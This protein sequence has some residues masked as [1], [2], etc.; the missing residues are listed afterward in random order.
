MT[1]QR[2]TQEIIEQ[3]PEQCPTCLLDDAPA[4]VDAF[5]SHEKLSEAM[6][7]LIVTETGGHAIAL[8]G[9]WGSGKS[10]VI[11]LLEKRLKARNEMLDARCFCF[12]AWRHSGDP[13]RR[14]F[15]EGIISFFA[16]VGWVVESDWQAD[17]DRLARR[18]EDVTQV[19]RQ[20]LTLTGGLVL[21]AALFV[22]IGYKLFE[23][24]LVNQ[25][26]WRFLVSIFLILLPVLVG[27]I[28][29][30]LQRH[31][32]RI[33]KSCWP[34][35]WGRINK[36]WPQSVRI[37]EQQEP[38]LAMLLNRSGETVRTASIRTPDPTTI[39]FQAI[40]ER[41]LRSAL[42]KSDRRL[43]II[44]DNL[45]R[46]EVSGAM[47]IWSTM[48]TFLAPSCNGG[49][50][51][52][53]ERL[54]LV[55]PFDERTP[56]RLWAR[57][58]D[59]AKD[60]TALA[61]A[62][63]EKTF[64]IIF[65]VPPPVLTDWEKLLQKLLRTAFP[66]HC[67]N[68][69]PVVF[70]LYDSHKKTTLTPRDLKLFVNKLGAYHRIWQDTIA[71]PIQAA[72]VL[73]IDQK[74]DVAERIISGT[75]LNQ[76]TIDILG[77]PDW[78]KII[79]ALYFGV[80]PDKA[81]HVLIGARLADALSTGDK[82]YI[83]EVAKSV[84]GFETVL[85][86]AVDE[87]SSQW[88]SKETAAIAKAAVA[89]SDF[90]EKTHDP[91]GRIW[92]HLRKTASKVVTWEA[93]N[94][95]TTAGLLV[96]FCT[97][98]LNERVSF[99]KQIIRSISATDLA[100]QKDSP[101]SWAVASLQLLKGFREEGISDEALQ[102]LK[103]PGNS[104][105]VLRVYRT[106]RANK[107]GTQLLPYYVPRDDVGTITNSLLERAKSLKFDTDDRD[108][109]ETM[110][111]VKAPW[112]WALF[113]AGVSNV[114][115]HQSG[116]TPKQFKPLLEALQGIAWARDSSKP[117]KEALCKLCNGGQL[118]HFLSRAQQEN[119]QEAAGLCMLSLVIEVPNGNT[120]AVW[121]AE[122]GR[123]IFN[124]VVRN[125]DRQ[126]KV[127][128][129]IASAILKYDLLDVFLDIPRKVIQVK[130]LAV[131]VLRMLTKK[132]DPY[133]HL[134]ISLFVKHSDLMWPALQKEVVEFLKEHP[135]K[136][137]LLSAIAAST[138]TQDRLQMYMDAYVC[139]QGEAH[140]EYQQFL[141]KGLKTIP[142]DSW[143]SDMSSAGQRL[144]AA[145]TLLK[146]GITLGLGEEFH[147][148]LLNL[149]K[150][151]RD[152]KT[153][154]PVLESNWSMLVSAMTNDWRLT[155]LNDVWDAILSEDQKP[156]HIIATIYGDALAKH[157]GD[158][159]DAS[160]K[161]VRK[162]FPRVLERKNTEEI[163][164]ACQFLKEEPRILTKSNVAS[165]NAL[166][167]R[168]SK[169]IDDTTEESLKNRILEFG[170]VLGM[171]ISRSGGT[172][173]K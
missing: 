33:L 122:Q 50:E 154:P 167:E 155:L 47:A 82:N 160:D 148:A 78:Q 143:L 173:D 38:I 32:W 113:A 41:L 79:A 121:N 45:D 67:A 115:N 63:I 145:I 91:F 21:F 72:F 146:N 159:A 73:N 84:P 124:Q 117:V 153:I 104:E 164:W 17:L 20:E 12:D 129:A 125:P 112:D 92:R 34:W 94:S 40:F 118:M 51:R 130:P 13:L 10:T 7:N 77:E 42:A 9:S 68:D 19:A 88:G 16:R 6:A 107:D 1:N 96:L 152:K 23:T 62:F 61:Q 30:C 74:D 119:D 75:F 168:V 14:T 43:A 163:A 140:V 128:E 150:S 120:P 53:S 31:M 166:N 106:L 101:D 60:E 132:E 90:K 123:Q 83:E 85:D 66:Q 139:C 39:E 137:E 37:K 144:T 56:R 165:R 71:L 131:M 5:G 172:Q 103:V 81:L 35:L 4:S 109:V 102:V 98:P 15:I 133:A 70:R 87:Q 95:D 127:V 105:T 8:V 57:G 136:A 161:T 54:W 48:Q 116:M 80:P 44:I 126:M 149:T 22:P 134:T 36:W 24:F 52:I 28:S 29:W 169:A 86:Q 46:I 97:C 49:A 65:R 11:R 55:V 64:Q 27:F 170:K 114:F 18:R 171:D 25:E 76:R 2:T 3:E 93:L 69:L 111:K 141:V 158:S 147:D 108:A 138:F 157:V 142:R 151:Q 89:L 99:A 26:V 162:L 59:G 156:V 58:S 110:C 100:M 135:Q